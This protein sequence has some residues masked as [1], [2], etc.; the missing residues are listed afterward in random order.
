MLSLRDKVHSPA[1]A[2]AQVNAYGRPPDSSGLTA[3][4]GEM[5]SAFRHFGESAAPSG[6]QSRLKTRRTFHVMKSAGKL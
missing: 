4:N 3:Q 2:C 1:E 5:Q 6:S